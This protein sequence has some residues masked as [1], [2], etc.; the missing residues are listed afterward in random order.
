MLI[1]GRSARLR[2]EASRPPAQLFGIPFII[3][4]FAGNLYSKPVGLGGSYS[5]RAFEAPVWRFALRRR[6][7]E[8]TSTLCRPFLVAIRVV[9]SRG[10]PPSG[11]CQF[12][13]G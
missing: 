13:G 11:K 8:P 9:R 10:R 7:W 12:K 1:G 2:Q 3:L 6:T 4:V 5:Q